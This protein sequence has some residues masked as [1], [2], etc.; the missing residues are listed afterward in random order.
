[1][2]SEALLLYFTLLQIAGAGFPEDSEPISI[3]HGNCKYIIFS[4]LFIHFFF[5]RAPSFPSLPVRPRPPPPRLPLTPTLARPLLSLLLNIPLST[6]LPVPPPPPSSPSTLPRSSLCPPC[7]SKAWGVIWCPRKG[8]LSPLEKKKKQKDLK[9]VFET[10]PTPTS[11]DNPL[12][13][14]RGP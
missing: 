8:F 12:F 1:M 6:L 11:K 13:F 5:A 9:R 2:R 4:T 3:S 14:C 7:D 10:E